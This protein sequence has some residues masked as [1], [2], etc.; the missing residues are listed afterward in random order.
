MSSLSIWAPRALTPDRELER[1]RLTVSGGRIADLAHGSDPAEG[2]RVF[3]DATLVPGLVD[4]QVNGAGGA[5]F[6]SASREERERAARYH[7]ERGTTSLLATL[8]SAPLDKQARIVR[9]KGN[10]IG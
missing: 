3:D 1:V 7:V 8:V 10:A 4:L 6:A 2:D 5:A 9:I